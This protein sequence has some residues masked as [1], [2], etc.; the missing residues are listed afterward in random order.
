M[1]LSSPSKTRMK[2]QRQKQRIAMIATDPHW[3]R[4]KAARR[5][6]S[7]DE[8]VQEVFGLQRQFRLQWSNQMP[9]SPVDLNMILK[10]LTQKRIPF[11][12]TGAHGIGA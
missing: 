10:T 6:L 3:E 11:V 12:L 8:G 5:S 2:T 9:A 4:A 1:A 7:H